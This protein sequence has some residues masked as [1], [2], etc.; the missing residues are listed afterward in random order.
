MATKKIAL[1]EELEHIFEDINKAVFG[2]SLKMPI[3]V[4]QPKKKDIFRFTPNSFHMTIGTGFLTMIP[5]IEADLEIGKWNFRERLV[6]EYVHEMCHVKNCLDKKEDCTSNQYHNKKFLD[7][8]L[9]AGFY[10][11]RRKNQG[12]AV[13]KLTGDAAHNMKTLHVYAPSDAENKIL[14]EVAKN[15]FFD[16]Q[17]FSSAAQRFRPEKKK[18]FFLRYE[19]ECGSSF[20]SGIRPTSPNAISASCNKCNSNFQCVEEY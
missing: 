4:F 8:A 3:H 5:K 20:R 19:C 10:V 12:Y 17:T 16:F 7:T 9:N 11:G 2:G 13:T 18:K 15:L 1:V 14:K 6:E